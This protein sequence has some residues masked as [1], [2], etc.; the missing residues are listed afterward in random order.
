MDRAPSAD[1]I[2][3]RPFARMP[4]MDQTLNAVNE[5]MEREA[6]TGEKTDLQTI[7]ARAEELKKKEAMRVF[8]EGVANGALQGEDT[9]G[10]GGGS[11]EPS[12]AAGNADEEEADDIET[13][14]TGGGMSSTTNETCRFSKARQLGE[15]VLPIP[16]TDQPL[17]TVS[18]A[19]PVNMPS[20][21]AQCCFRV[22]GFFTNA[23][24]RDDHLEDLPRSNYYN[25]PAAQPFTFGTKVFKTPEENLAFVDKVLLQWKEFIVQKNV[26]FERYVE[27]RQKKDAALEKKLTEEEQET[28]RKRN[29]RDRETTKL[30]DESYKKL[31]KEGRKEKKMKRL[32]ASHD[33]RG[34]TH[35]VV[36]L[37]YDRDEED[38]PVKSQWILVVWG[39]FPSEKEAVAYMSDTIQH[40]RRYMNHFVVKMY[41]IIYPDLVTTKALRRKTKG[42]FRFQEQQELWSSAFNNARNVKGYNAAMDQE[43]TAAALRKALQK[44]AEAA[45][46]SSAIELY[47]V[48]PDGP[49]DRPPVTA[50]AAPPA[51]E[52]EA[53]DVEGKTSERGEDE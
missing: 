23:E 42:I 49:L 25:V 50:E 46:E 15:E 6:L 11:K 52:E 4:D 24:E 45:G 1:S 44:D 26:E 21:S 28:F 39:G 3:T 51:A 34:Q 41:E 5:A 22:V 40:E 53:I 17:A 19:A 48:K 29:Q 38:E 36:S 18:L 20:K 9:G 14:L 37:L 7:R 27:D 16:L 32:K 12:T 31:K 10:G 8:R 33:V 43:N 2:Q 30:L 35:A 47:P 13:Y